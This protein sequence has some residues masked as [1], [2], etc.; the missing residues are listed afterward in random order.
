[1]RAD[2]VEG[3]H[4]AA[5]RAAHDPEHDGER[6]GVFLRAGPRP[7]DARGAGVAH[8][9]Q[10]EHEADGEGIA[11]VH[12]EDHPPHQQQAGGPSRP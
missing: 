11:P 10:E 3:V 5:E 12:A 7:E 1:M 2:D 6:N 4:A 8:R 9:Q